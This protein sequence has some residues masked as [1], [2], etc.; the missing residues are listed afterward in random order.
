MQHSLKKVAQGAGLVLLLQL[1]PLDARADSG[2]YLGVGAGGA[3]LEA[4]LGPSAFGGL[5][6]EIDEDDTAVK[7]FA[8]YQFDTPVVDLGIEAGYVD[9]GEPDIDTGGGL[10]L[11]DPTGINL[12]GTAAFDLGPAAVYGKLGILAW[13]IESAFSGLSVSEDG[14]DVAYGAGVRFNLGALQIRGEYEIYDLDG[15]DLA[16]LSLGVAW[17]FD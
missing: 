16:M 8:G 6:T 5:P 4:D 2:F 7:V 13:D 10:L 3:T 1:V 11:L 17:L 15:D 9:F 14:T 12:W